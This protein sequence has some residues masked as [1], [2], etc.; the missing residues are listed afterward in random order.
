MAFA[1][2]CFNTA[3]L[4][5]RATGY[6]FSLA[7]WMDQ[8]DATIAKTDEREWGAICKEI[9]KAGYTAVEIWQAHADPS[10]MTEAK[11]RIWKQALADHGLAPVAYAGGLTVDTARVC[12][13]LGIPHVDGGL[14][15][16]SAAE[17]AALCARTGIL[18]NH[19]NHPEQSPDEIKV[20]VAGGGDWVGV[21]LDTGWLGTQG[22]DAPRAIH[23]L[24][25]LVRHVHLKDVKA[26]GGHETCPL[27]EGRVG[28]DD[29][30]VTLKQAG[31]TGWISWEDEPEDRN[32]FDI[33][34]RMR[35]WIDARIR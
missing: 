12:T 28:V 25:P 30:L 34:A 31:Y 23:E 33:A 5:G 8:H 9:A 29:C 4:V 17:V 16:R 26:P 3:N 11:A 27:G 10:V 6:R 1:G 35:E 18:A 22:V 19:E 32:P 21:A 13:W 7:R 14:G 2:I 24:G 20:R 15:S